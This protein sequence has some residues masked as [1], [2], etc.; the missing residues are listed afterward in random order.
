[1]PLQRYNP[2]PQIQHG[3]AVMQAFRLGIVLGFAT[4][5]WLMFLYGRLKALV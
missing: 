2:E 3:D 1:M 4:A 5:C